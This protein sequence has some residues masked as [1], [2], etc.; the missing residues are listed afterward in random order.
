MQ[1]THQ[2]LNPTAIT[3]DAWIGG[4]ME[5][6]PEMKILPWAPSAPH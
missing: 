2:A 1:K 5:V 6:A 3:F 4:E